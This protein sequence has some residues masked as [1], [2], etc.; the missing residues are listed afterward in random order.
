MSDLLP[1][2][3][4]VTAPPELTY[5]GDILKAVAAQ[6]SALTNGAL[7]GEV[8]AMELQGWLATYDFNAI[9]TRKGPGYGLMQIDHKLAEP[10]PVYVSPNC[11]EEEYWP[12]PPMGPSDPSYRRGQGAHN[13]Q[14][15]LAL[16]NEVLASPQARRLMEALIR[17]RKAMAEGDGV[18]KNGP[19]AGTVEPAQSDVASH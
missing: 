7:Q 9:V 11:Y 4:T 14:E 8:W 12:P 18:A 10:Y 5:P 17:Q 2:D 16:I 15:F 3:M 13:P 6:I 19:P 1:Q